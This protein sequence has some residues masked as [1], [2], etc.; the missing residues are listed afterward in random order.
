MYQWLTAAHRSHRQFTKVLDRKKPNEGADDPESAQNASKIEKL[1]Q[2][3]P[4][5]TYRSWK[6]N[7]ESVNN[8]AKQGATFVA[9]YVF[10]FRL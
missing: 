1:N 4:S 10:S 7:N 9:W 8:S 3:A 5:R 2:M 6:E